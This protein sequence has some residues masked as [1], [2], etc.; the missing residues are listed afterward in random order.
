MGVVESGLIELEAETVAALLAAGEAVVVDVREIHEWSA[1]RI[2][3]AVWQPLSEFDAES[4]PSF[5]GRKTVIACKGGIRSALLAER[6][7]AAGHPWAI[8]LKGGLEAWKDAGLPL[9]EGE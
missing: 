2:A 3:G 1:E 8:H 4:W 9:E 5:P 6:L 7:M